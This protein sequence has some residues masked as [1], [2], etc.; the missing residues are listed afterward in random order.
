MQSEYT[1]Q[2]ATRLTIAWRQ[3]TTTELSVAVVDFIEDVQNSC[4][5]RMIER[6]SSSFVLQDNEGGVYLFLYLPSTSTWTCDYELT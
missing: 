3:W 6:D 5:N 1:E 2:L 4:N